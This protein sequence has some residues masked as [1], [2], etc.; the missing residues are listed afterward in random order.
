[1][2]ETL[3]FFFF[4]W[5]V[6]LRSAFASSIIIQ[7]WIRIPYPSPDVSCG[8]FI[9]TRNYYAHITCAT[10]RLIVNSQKLQSVEESHATIYIFKNS[11]GE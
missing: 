11:L 10:A 5:P 9:L 7:C 8:L 6:T 1:M 2:G 3:D 4:E